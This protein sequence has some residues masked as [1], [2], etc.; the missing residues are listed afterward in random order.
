MTP[1]ER[2]AYRAFVREHHPDRGG[3]PDAFVAGLAAMRARP[4][5]DVEDDVVFVR[6]VP[7]PTRIAIAL[8][9]TVRRHRRFSE[10]DSDGPTSHPRSAP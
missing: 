7:L 8:L 5:S 6:D 2:A 10:T 9:R 3:D 4:E 1:E